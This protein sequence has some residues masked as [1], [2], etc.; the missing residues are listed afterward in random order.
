[1]ASI[2]IQVYNEKTGLYD[3]F[4][5][6]AA[7]SV[8]TQHLDLIDAVEYLPDFLKES[9]LMVS[10]VDCLNALIS[11][12][13]PV[14]AEVFAAYNDMMYKIK[15]YSILSYEA[16]IEVVKELGFEYLLDILTLSSDQL[17]QL[18][19]FFNLIYI[20]KGK[21][22]GLELCLQTL[23]MTYSYT[24]WDETSPKG[25]PFTANL[26]IIGN[27]YSDSEVFKKIRTFIRSYMLP[28]INITIEIYVE[29]PPMYAYP[30]FGMLNKLSISNPFIGIRDVVSIAIYDSEPA[31]D[32]QYYGANINNGPNM[33]TP[34]PM[35][36]STLTIETIPRSAIV[37]IDG[38]ETNAKQLEQGKLVE[39]TAQASGYPTYK[40]KIVLTGDKTIKIDLTTF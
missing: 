2:Q 1:M 7:D 12:K 36:L 34:D 22:E 14:F 16:K 6:K 8:S 25:T 19:I 40:N 15:D 30:S 26:K 5:N 11:D 32:T 10:I 20:L 37:T 27:D 21:R 28:W 17:T 9:P 13:R 31:Y 33:Y 38:E 18:L 23:G 4:T 35:P 3:T 29:A 24:T 39:Y